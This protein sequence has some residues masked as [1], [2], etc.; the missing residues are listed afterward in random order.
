[1]N[2]VSREIPKS[3]IWSPWS[4]SPEAEVATNSFQRPCDEVFQAYGSGTEENDGSEDGF[5]SSFQ[6]HLLGFFALR[7]SKGPAPH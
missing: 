6:K 7:D 5:R 2:S 4:S 3:L 1:M